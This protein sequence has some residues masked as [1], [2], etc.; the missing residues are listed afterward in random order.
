MDHN[1]NDRD[2]DV[3]VNVTAEDAL[4]FHYRRHAWFDPKTAVRNTR[5]H[6]LATLIEQRVSQAIERNKPLSTAL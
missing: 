1:V 6:R 3:N 4:L 2:H 5:L